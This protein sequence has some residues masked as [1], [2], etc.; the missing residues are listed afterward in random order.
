MFILLSGIALTW[1]VGKEYQ[2]KRVLVILVAAGLV[3]APYIASVNAQ[4][5]TSNRPPIGQPLVS[6]GEF[7]VELATALNLSL[8][9]E[10]A[11]AEDALGSI[12]I[13]PRNGW[14]SDYPI[15]PDIIAEVRESAARSASSGSLKMAEIEATGIVDSVSTAM[16]LPIEVAGGKGAYE[17]GSSSNSSSG[18]ESGSSF[19]YQSSS[20]SEYQSSSGAPPPE[21]S[22]YAG[23]AELKDTITITD[24]PSSAIIHLRGATVLSMPGS[25]GHSGG[26]ASASAAS[27][28]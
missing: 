8:S 11:A 28:S 10:E 12:S 26:E 16:N 3:L 14:I 19:E 17:S 4:S 25:P 27:S 7:A 20:S 24:R 13:A 6:E 21:V 23:P 1:S 2:M 9:H 22:E 18:Y 15:T 5:S